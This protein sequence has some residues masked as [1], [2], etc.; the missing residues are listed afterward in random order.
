MAQLADNK[1]KQEDEKKRKRAN[2]FEGVFSK[3]MEGTDE[4][5]C[6]TSGYSRNARKTNY[7]YEK[8]EYHL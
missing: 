7:S 4:M 2:A 3:A 8:K 6:K 5:N 1:R